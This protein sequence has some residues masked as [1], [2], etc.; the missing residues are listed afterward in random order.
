LSF[1]R[2]ELLC[3]VLGVEPGSVTPLAIVNDSDGRITPVLDAKL[4][5]QG[6]VN[7]HLLRN[8]ATTAIRGAD[9]LRFIRSTGH[10]PLLLDLD[11]LLDPV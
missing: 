4:A 10:E 8:D 6:I 1:G 11:A 5:A 3:E 2:S 9:L 7:C